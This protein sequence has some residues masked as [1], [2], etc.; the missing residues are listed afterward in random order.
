MKRDEI[1]INASLSDDSYK[2]A[3]NNS[4]RTILRKKIYIIQPLINCHLTYAS[5]LM[6]KRAAN[7]DKF[8]NIHLTLHLH[9]RL[10]DALFVFALHNKQQLQGLQS[11]I[12]NPRRV[13]D[14]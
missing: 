6:L 4:G 12:M 14:E 2:K 3:L 10:I 7:F 11:T 5:N 8:I 1:G 9:C 13:K